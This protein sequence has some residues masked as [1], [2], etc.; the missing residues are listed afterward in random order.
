[1]CS[2]RHFM[3]VVCSLFK[4]ILPPLLPT[5]FL[6]FSFCLS[7]LISVPEFFSCP[8]VCLETVRL[9]RSHISTP[10]WA[11]IVVHCQIRVAEIYRANYY[12]KEACYI[13]AISKERAQRIKR[14]AHPCQDFHALNI[15]RVMALGRSKKLKYNTAQL[16]SW[17]CVSFT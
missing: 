9:S 12:Q 7:S 8:L 11:L 10:E 1:M 15:Y 14:V 2:S 13:F 17:V 4:I 3:L 16:L 6:V 5:C